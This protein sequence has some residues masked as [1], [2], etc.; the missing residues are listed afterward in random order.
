[1]ELYQ[2]VVHVRRQ[3]SRHHRHPNRN[4][5]TYHQTPRECPNSRT[6]KK[7]F[8]SVTLLG[9]TGSFC[10]YGVGTRLRNV[11]SREVMSGNHLCIP[12]TN[13][14]M[15]SQPL[16][17]VETA[18]ICQPKTGSSTRKWVAGHETGP[19]AMESAN[20]NSSFNAPNVSCN[21]SLFVRLPFLETARSRL[22]RETQ[23]L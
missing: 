17:L 10:R 15:P 5:R 16:I 2:S 9:V 7:K 14:S 4:T 3:N 6:A 8:L 13:V 19:H 22:R 1:M 23:L 21:C 20:A 12:G 11:A 18:L